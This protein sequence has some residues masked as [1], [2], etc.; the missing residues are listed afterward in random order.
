MPKLRK[1]AVLHT[2]AAVSALKLKLV[3]ARVQVLFEGGDR[4]IPLD[5]LVFYLYCLGRSTAYI[6]EIHGIPLLDVSA[7]IDELV[8]R[9]LVVE[10]DKMDE[11]VAR[12][13]AAMLKPFGHSYQGFNLFHP[14]DKTPLSLK[15]A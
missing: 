13:G 8:R 12:I 11:S 2:G 10:N 15:A 1:T 7:C 5:L 6:I 9:K 4:V 3:A 14:E